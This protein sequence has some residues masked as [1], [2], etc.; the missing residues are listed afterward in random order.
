MRMKFLD[1][2]T[3]HAARD[4]LGRLPADLQ[5]EYAILFGSRARGEGRPDSDVDLALIIAEWV[6]EWEFVGK[7]ASCGALRAMG[8]FLG[9]PLNSKTARD[10]VS[11]GE[12]SCQSRPPPLPQ[13]S[14]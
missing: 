12:H 1:P 9:K 3:E 13:L 11:V 6:F 8:L 5:L 2:D 7:L 4:F 14:V 10:A